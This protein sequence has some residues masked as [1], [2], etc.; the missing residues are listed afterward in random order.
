MTF[1]QT[2]SYARR[3]FVELWVR[4]S[5]DHPSFLELEREFLGNDIEE[6]VT[7]AR[8]LL[9][10]DE[11]LPETWNA[12]VCLQ[13][14]DTF[15]AEH[16]GTRATGVD[17]QLGTRVR[18]EDGQVH[19]LY[20]RPQ[21]MR[22]A[23]V[24]KQSGH[25]RRWM[26][27]HQVLPEK[28]RGYQIDLSRPGDYLFEALARMREHGEPL[29]VAF[30][31]FEDGVTLSCQQEQSPPRFRA[32]TL[33]APATR[34][35]TVSQFL[36]RA[37]TA[38]AHVLVLP[39]LTVSPD[40]RLQIQ[41]WLSDHSGEHSLVLVLPGT[42]H[43]PGSAGRT[44]EVVNR[45]ELLDAYGQPALTHCKLLP[46]TH[47]MLGVE[48][49]KPGR[50]ISLLALPLGL[51][52]TPICLDFCEADQPLSEIWKQL[53]PAWLLVPAMG[54]GSN[55][56]AHATAARGLF[57]TR[58]SVTVLANQPATPGVAAPGFVCDSLDRNPTEWDSKES[59]PSFEV[60]EVD[61]SLEEP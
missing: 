3:R 31:R 60:V 50:R 47:P 30:A 11:A 52:A 54:D 35:E 51:L 24:E 26:R 28:P 55:R 14:L 19:L 45:T 9:D 43:E 18:L 27:H 33:S 53:G 8:T 32:E 57:I 17:A 44:G 13:A 38:G 46:F 36:E 10:R 12:L 6:T 40:L 34:W 48:D 37:R 5:D 39:E 42:F 2:L 21:G 29:K 58:G 15:L 23:P 41:K 20:R 1:E 4:L 16:S 22:R 25:L 59:R 7:G 49:I 61:I 56:R